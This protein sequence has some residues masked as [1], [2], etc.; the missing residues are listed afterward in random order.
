MQVRGK[1]AVKE[2]FFVL[3]NQ[4]EAL[5]K[6][7]YEEQAKRYLATYFLIHDASQFIRWKQKGLLEL[8]QMLKY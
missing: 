7:I 6:T 4:M 3:I 1:I 8:Q 5:R 2:K